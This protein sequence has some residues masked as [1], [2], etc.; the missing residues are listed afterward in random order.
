MSCRLRS[1]SRQEVRELDVRAAEQL[2]LPT[3]ILMENAGRGAAAW[4]VEL[5][6]GVRSESAARPFSAPP[7][8]EIELSPAAALPRVLIISGP[9]NNGGDGGVVARH[10]DAWG[11]AVRIVWFANLNQLRGDAKSQWTILERSGV[12]QTVWFQSPID[13]PRPAELESLAAD[14]DWLVDG[15]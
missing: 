1:L 11:F 9:G 8:V 7:S 14:A 13:D 2:G 15:L 5:A 3:L 10:L 4:L 6:A 12:H